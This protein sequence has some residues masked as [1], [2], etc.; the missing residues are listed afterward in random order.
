MQTDATHS[1]R[2]LRVGMVGLG[3]IFDDT[4]GPLLEHLHAEGLYR[5]DFGPVAVDLVAVATRT[6]TRG[7]RLR[8]RSGS[9]L[10]SFVNCKGPGAI[11]E[12]LAAGI[13]VVC[14]ATPDDR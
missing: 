7:D 6:G 4:Y 11:D 14:V 12:M 2:R 3:M 5:R 8:D 10:G 1:T 13:D 9:T